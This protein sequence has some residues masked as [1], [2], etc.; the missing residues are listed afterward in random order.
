MRRAFLAAFIVLLAPPAT[1]QPAGQE[2]QLPAYAGSFGIEE[3]REFRRE[4]GIKSFIIP[5]HY[6]YFKGIEARRA[7]KRAEA[8][9]FFERSMEMDPAF[10]DPRFSLARLQMFSNPSAAL[11][12]LGT[13]FDIL[14]NEFRYQ[15]LMV[16]N[17]VLYLVYVLLISTVLVASYLLVRGWRHLAHVP[18]EALTKPLGP[19]I[20]PLASWLVVGAPLAAGAG[21]LATLAFYLGWLQP[22]LSSA[23]RR[24]IV[25][26]LLAAALTG[27][28][29]FTFPRLIA[30]MDPAEPV[31]TAALA[32]DIGYSD[33]LEQRLASLS[34]A[35]PEN[36]LLH[37]VRALNLKRGGRYED[38]D[39]AFA[40]AEHALGPRSE[41][42][43]NQGN[44]ALIAK[45]DA[46][47]EAL[48][49]KALERDPRSVE[50][51]FNLSQ[52][53]TRRLDF[54]RADEELA[55]ANACDFERVA[56]MARY[57][58]AAPHLALMDAT[59]APSIF[60]SAALAG[61]AATAR[62][63]DLLAT[64]APRG[65]LDLLLP[66]A[67]ILWL[68]GLLVSRR[69]NAFLGT[70]GCANCGRVVCRRC[71]RRLEGHAY[72]RR[73]GEAL[74]GLRSPE[75]SALLLDRLIEHEGQGVRILT[76]TAAAIFPGMS[77]VLAGRL[78]AAWALT[79]CTAAILVFVIHR[80]LV[81]NA[82]PVLFYQ[83]DFSTRI[84]FAVAA[85]LLLYGA[86]FWSCLSVPAAQEPAA[87]ERMAA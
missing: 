63:P 74:A 68:L 27:T 55:Q 20:A 30:A 32:Q 77:L 50:A 64:F 79:V 6:F 73:C 8:Q 28:F 41:G 83:E 86:S 11:S 58:D 65:R 1:A 19:R 84:P 75:Y 10:P 35:D 40:Q 80:G 49:R 81:I 3:L 26:L 82:Y 23:E 46:K 62:P 34:S 14:S 36:G 42:L 18:E 61:R 67:F 71:V 72:C 66:A 13:A 54:V 15:H 31:Y 57:A 59:L 51:H 69:A 48:Y 44:L 70:N 43:V 52:V 45:D 56:E 85:T 87:T 7:G 76:G 4:H 2:F 12:H 78:R 37:F 22:H 39:A 53:Y 5:A 29:Y 21:I 47:A 9:E 17:G 16:V 25:V 38:A 33:R 60:W 24:F